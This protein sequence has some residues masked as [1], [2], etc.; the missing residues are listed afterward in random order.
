MLGIATVKCKIGIK[1]DAEISLLGD[2]L[3]PE[4]SDTAPDHV[5]VIAGQPK[6]GSRDPPHG[7]H[8]EHRHHGEARGYRADLWT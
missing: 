3:E 1:H 6:V 8:L 5:L 7:P 4:H 2:L